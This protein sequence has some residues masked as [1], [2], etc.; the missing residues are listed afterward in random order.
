MRIAAPIV[1]A[2]VLSGSASAATPQQLTFT[3]SD[4]VTLACSLV[5]PDGTPPAGG[6][7]AAMLFHG[8]GQTHL[9]IEAAAL[10]LFAPAGY[11]SLMCDARGVGA[12]G[13]LFG[14]DGP[15]DVEDA[16]EL[17]AWLTARPEI[18]DTA[19]GAVGSSLG[20][21]AVWNAAVAGVPF[22][23]IVPAAAWTSL[24]PALAPGGLAKSGLLTSLAALVPEARWES[25][26]LAAR[27]SLLAGTTTN[28]VGAIAAARSSRAKL[29]SLSVPALLLQGRRDSLFDIDQALAAYRALRGPK[30]LY[31][32][33][34][35]HAPARN[36]GAETPTYDREVV[37]WLDRFVRGVQNGVERLPPIALAH[38]PWDG[39]VTAYRLP[40]ETKTLSVSL[41]GTST[42]AG[43]S[44]KV[45][46]GA[47]FT[48]GPHETFG[49]SS[50]TVRYSNA[51][52][53]DRLVAV[54]AV[55]PEAIAAGGVRLGAAS[56]T[57][58]IP[59]PSQ[60]FRF[61]AGSRVVVYLSSTSLAQSPA[62][63]LYRDGV[64]PAAR[65]T[66]GR[67]TLSLSVLTR[68]VSR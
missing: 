65:I 21:G 37:R 9:D 62:D 18:S 8:L 3:A 57:A 42:I 59:L 2:L 20:G 1:A 10:H 22:R 6:W 25:D 15:R 49:P 40:P 4:G 52:G 47:R 38:D 64:Q 17:F 46:R 35:G 26:L 67:A 63:T 58:T 27:A 13:G 16:R 48:G 53:W 39:K 55:G 19:V 45:V 14:L 30:R 66:I 36:P 50:V 7:P 12:S 41:P 24:L 5:V 51:A 44:G 60:A 54:V 34:F 61:R 43:A 29:A 32:G 56:G 28:G 31:I 23:A 33:D 11:A 68:A